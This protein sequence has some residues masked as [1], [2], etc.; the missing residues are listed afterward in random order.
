MKLLKAIKCKVIDEGEVYTSYR[1]WIR[2]F[3]PDELE[4]YNFIHGDSPTVGQRLTLIGLVD[5][6]QTLEDTICLV[7]SDHQQLF[8]ISIEGLEF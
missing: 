4:K 3:F 1:D 5:G 2:R 6:S 8:M 7:L